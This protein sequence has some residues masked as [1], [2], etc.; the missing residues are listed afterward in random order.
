MYVWIFSSSP[1]CGHIPMVSHTHSHSSLHL[2]WASLHAA[3]PTLRSD[4]Q[5]ARE[6]GE[7]NPCISDDGLASYVSRWSLR[8]QKFSQMGARSGS[9]QR[10]TAFRD[11]FPL[12]ET[13]ENQDNVRN[14]RNGAKS[15]RRS[16]RGGHQIKKHLPDTRRQKTAGIFLDVLENHEAGHVC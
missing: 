5:H 9:L 15:A 3:H 10:A 13:L 14:D 8:A 11:G 4:V 6:D 2:S 12:P 7:R 1:G 16:G